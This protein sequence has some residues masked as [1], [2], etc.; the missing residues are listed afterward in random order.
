MPDPDSPGDSFLVELNA[1]PNGFDFPEGL[2]GPE[3][4]RKITYVRALFVAANIDPLAEIAKLRE[5]GC[6]FDG[7]R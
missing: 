2:E 1:P 3:L 4:E 7:E 5:A 6:T